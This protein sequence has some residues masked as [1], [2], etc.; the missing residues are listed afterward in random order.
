MIE[1]SLA[2]LVVGVGFAAGVIRGFAGFGGPAFIIAVLTWFMSPVDVIDKVMVI[3]FFVG[4]Y[5]LWEVRKRIDWPTTLAITIPALIGMPFGH[6]ILLNTD[7]D[8]MRR[9]I[10]G[11]ILL[12][13]IVMLSN[14]RFKSR[15]SLPVL[16]TIGLIGGVIF[17]ASYIAL[18]LV[19]MVLMASYDRSE[20]RTLF[21]VSGFMFACWFLVLSFHQEQTSFAKVIAAIPIMVGYLAGCWL[22]ARLFQDSTEKSY[23]RYALYLLGSLAIVGLLR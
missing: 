17:G 3:E 15:Y 16:I 1:G 14:I 12:A 19:S 4:A 6:W 13:S 7:A 5:L 20:I 11:L 10:A 22:G 21:F 18:V 8:L 2:F 9:V 23:R